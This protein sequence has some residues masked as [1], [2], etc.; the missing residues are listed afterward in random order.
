MIR[1]LKKLYDNS[2]A[3]LDAA[4]NRQNDK[5]HFNNPAK[6]SFISPVLTVK[7]VVTPSKKL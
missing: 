4:N 6:Q 3:A 2:K 7:K 5:G 1:R